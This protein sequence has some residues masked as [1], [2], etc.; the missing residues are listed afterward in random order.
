MSAADFLGAIRR[1]ESL[2]EHVEIIGDVDLG[3]VTID[4]LFLHHSSFDGKVEGLV[5]IGEFRV[6]SNT[7]YYYNNIDPH[8]YVGSLIKDL[9][10]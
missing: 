4:K 9:T 1:G 2:F 10:S 5:T 6:V 8:T 3:T 7:C